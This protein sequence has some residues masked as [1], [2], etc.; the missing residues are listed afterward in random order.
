MNVT[1]SY[2][3]EFGNICDCYSK[4]LLGWDDFR[5]AIEELNKTIETN[6]RVL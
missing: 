6:A 5:Y 4:G 1:L 3:E 2:L